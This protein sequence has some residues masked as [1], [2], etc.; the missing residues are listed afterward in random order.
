MRLDRDR[1]CGKFVV[2]FQSLGRLKIASCLTLDLDDGVKVNYSK[3]GDLLAEV[4][5][6]HG[7]KPEDV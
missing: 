4:K 5:A 2:T 6:V 3:F 7:Q 1:V